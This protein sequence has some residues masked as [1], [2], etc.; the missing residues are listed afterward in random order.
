M[1][2]LRKITVKQPG[3]RGLDVTEVDIAEANRIIK[4]VVQWGSIVIDGKTREIIWEIGLDVDEIEI[5]E[6]LAGG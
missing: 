5:V 2:S 4:E 3:R 1:N 6:M